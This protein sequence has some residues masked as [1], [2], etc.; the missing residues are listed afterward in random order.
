MNITIKEFTDK[1]RQMGHISQPLDIS[2]SR[3]DNRVWSIL[4]S[5]GEKNVIVSYY[6]NRKDLGEYGFDILAE[7]RN[8]FNIK[9]TNIF[10]AIDQVVLGGKYD[11]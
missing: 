7:K 5:P 1:I 2:Y 9:Y 3:A 11:E 8:Y 4:I 10:D 6:K